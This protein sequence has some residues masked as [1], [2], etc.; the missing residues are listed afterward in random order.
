MRLATAPNFRDLGG[1]AADGGTIRRGLVFRSEALLQPTEADAAVLDALGIVLVCDLRSDDERGHAPN[2]WWQE[3]GI[4]HLDLDVLARIPEADQPWALIRADPNS[5]GARAAML[6]TYTV[7]PAAAAPD[8][9][10]I[11]RRIAAGHL[12]LL[13]HCTAGKDR[14][15]FVSAM[16]LGALGVARADIVADYLASAGRRT[17]AAT[18]ATRLLVRKRAGPDVG[19]MAV[20]TMMGVAVDYLDASFTAIDR[21]HGSIDAYLADAGLDRATLAAVRERLVG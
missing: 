10:S 11:L 7:L 14:T 4:E 18:A 3:R 15:G 20:E 12:P 1:M 8:L 5:A 21:G 13:I 9:A 6:R 16:L 17:A 2:R 19:E